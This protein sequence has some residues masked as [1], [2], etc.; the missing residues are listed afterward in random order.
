VLLPEITLK[1]LSDVMKLSRRRAFCVV[2][3]GTIKRDLSSLLN[4]ST[5]TE[6]SGHTGLVSM[7][8]STSSD[9]STSGIHFDSKTSGPQEIGCINYVPYVGRLAPT[10]SGYMHGMSC[11]DARR[12]TSINNT[13]IAKIYLLFLCNNFEVK[14]RLFVQKFINDLSAQD[15]SN[16]SY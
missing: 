8:K 4:T 12:S 1:T 13:A 16:Y 3:R 2:S 6:I 5:K 15:S 7:L 10:P 11:R 14:L 9:D